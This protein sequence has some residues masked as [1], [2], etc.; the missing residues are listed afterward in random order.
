[1]VAPLQKEDVMKFMRSLDTQEALLILE[2]IRNLDELIAVAVVDAS[3][4]V[5]VALRE[6]GVDPATLDFAIAKARTA[7]KFQRDTVSFRHN[8]NKEGVWELSG[9]DGWNEHD[10]AMAAKHT[11]Y[12]CSWAGGTIVMHEKEAWVMGGVGVSGLDELDDHTL[13]QMRP[14]GGPWLPGFVPG[15]QTNLPKF[16][17]GD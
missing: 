15:V 1:M 14:S 16:G 12:F 17:G 8:L 10:L 9:H 5:L 2:N 7:V 3:G 13:S 4:D 6:D 11:P